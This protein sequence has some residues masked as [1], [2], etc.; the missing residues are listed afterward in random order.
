MFAGTAA[1]DVCSDVKKF[2]DELKS[3]NTG[4]QYF[5]VKSSD[6]AATYRRYINDK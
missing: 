2:C 6:L 4:K 1:G 3:Q 5:F